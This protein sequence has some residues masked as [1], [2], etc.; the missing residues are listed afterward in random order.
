MV[1]LPHWPIPGTLGNRK[2]DYETVFERM[3]LVLEK[4]GNPQEKLPPVIHVAGTNGKGSATSLIS[5]I[6]SLKSF[7][8][9]CIVS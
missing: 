6:F 1:Y 5:E 7:S 3:A 2:I 9:S 4:L 8:I